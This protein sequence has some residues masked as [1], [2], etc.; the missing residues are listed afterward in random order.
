MMPSHKDTGKI[1]HISIDYGTKR[2]NRPVRDAIHTILF[3]KISVG[4]HVGR[5]TIN[6]GCQARATFDL[7]LGKDTIVLVGELLPNAPTPLPSGIWGNNIQRYRECYDLVPW[8]VYHD[9]I[10]PLEFC[11]EMN[12]S[13]TSLNLTPNGTQ[14]SAWASP[15]LSLERPV[16]KLNFDADAFMPNF[17]YGRKVS[18]RD[19]VITSEKRWTYYQDISRLIKQHFVGRNINRSDLYKA[20]NKLNVPSVINSKKQWTYKNTKELLFILVEN[21]LLDEDRIRN[22]QLSLFARENISEMYLSILK[23]NKDV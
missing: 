11:R 8:T 10:H 5:G 4:S 23:E 18:F 17:I 9:G 3:K 20:L 7:R 2:E 1:M 21:G 19:G 6:K 15:F 16:H 14:L 13:Q 22:N 12:I